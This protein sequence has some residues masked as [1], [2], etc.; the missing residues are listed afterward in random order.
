MDQSSFALIVAAARREVEKA[1]GNA[2]RKAVEA[3]APAFVVKDGHLLMQHGGTVADLGSVVGPRGMDGFGVKGD[4]GADGIDGKDGRDGIDGKGID[5]R[6][7]TDGQDGKDG[8]DGA[9][10]VSI[11]GAKVSEAGFLIISFSDGRNITAG[12]VRGPKG[13][14]GDRGAAGI[15]GGAVMFGGGG[16]SSGGEAAWGGITGTL[17]DQTDLQSALDGKQSAGA[18]ALGGGGSVSVNFG[19][20]PGTNIIDQ[21][22]TVALPP[23]ARVR[24][25]V[26]GSTSDHNGYEHRTILAGRVAASV[27]D[28]TETG[29]LIT[30]ATELRLTGQIAATYE[31][32]A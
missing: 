19:S 9:D 21:P 32:S 27:S 17:S 11:T 20:A 14:K 26:S 7:G 15:S 2:D 18:Y 6:D 3:F 29:F 4:K 16:S 1:L 23:D 12:Y 25:W 10:G 5:G 22:V 28:V 30:L 8:I 31:W 24:A 13:D